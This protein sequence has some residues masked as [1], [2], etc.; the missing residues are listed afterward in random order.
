VPTN[1]ELWY[2]HDRSK[3]NPALNSNFQNYTTNSS[4]YSWTST[5]VTYSGYESKNWVV[6]N[7]DGN[8]NWG[9]RT[10][11]NY[12]RCVNG[13]SSYEFEDDEFERDH[14]TDIVTDK[15]HGLMWQDD[16]SS[17]RYNY[18]E[19][20]SYCSNLTLGGYSDWRFPE[21]EEL[22]S[23][24]DQSKTSA[25]SVNSNF[26][27]IKNLWYWSNTTVKSNSSESWVVG[28]NDGG[29]GWIGHAF[30]GFVVCVRDME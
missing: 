2:L 28:L 21:I 30:D 8:D 10:D 9:S 12:I 22:Y 26:K 6:S 18:S 16:S 14:L 27:N 19:A 1:K 20:Q 3:F 24:V 15:R 17:S 4:A 7:Y 5:P 29:D 23:I 11:S 25:P 13:T